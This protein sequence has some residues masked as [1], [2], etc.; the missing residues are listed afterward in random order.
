MKKI[1][2]NDNVQ[3][4]YVPR[5]PRRGTWVAD[6]VRFMQRV[7]ELEKQLPYCS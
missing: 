7:R 1:T 2:F 3:V 6:R 5:E 4:K